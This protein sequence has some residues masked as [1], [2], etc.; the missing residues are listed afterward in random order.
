MR[1]LLSLFALGLAACSGPALFAGDGDA[2]VAATLSAQEIVMT[3]GVRLRLTRWGSESPRAVVLG[4]HGFNDHGGSFDTLARRL[5]GQDIAFYSYDQR[6]FGASDHPGR[7]AGHERMASDAA[8]TAALLRERYPDLPLYLV[9]KSM[10]GAVATLALVDH[11]PPVDGA[12]LIA[13]AMWGRQT[14][15]WYQRTALWLSRRLL[16]GVSFSGRFLQRF[17]EI[18]P[19]D[20]P[21]VMAQMRA[22]PLVLKR[23]RS[24][25]LDGVTTLMDEALTRIGALPGPALI[26][27][28]GRDDIIPRAAACAMVERLAGNGADWRLGYYPEGY[29]MLT[30]Q[31]AAGP[32]IDDIA[33]WLL[34]PTADL[35]SDGELAR[36]AAVATI[37]AG[38]P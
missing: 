31:L 32:V 1:L 33:A 2:A 28:G 36:A 11:A 35:P 37:C 21:T 12:I 6:G 20:D 24:D 14:M 17:V 16:P 29:H 13:P 26:L 30:R 18:R 23:T 15:P 25:A 8:R 10:G 4:L 5:A 3:D 22:D 38:D 34:S 19:T 27:Y 9:G 7:W